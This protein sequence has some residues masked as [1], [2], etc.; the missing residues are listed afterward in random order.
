MNRFYLKVSERAQ[1]V[2]EYCRAPELASNFP[3]EVEHIRPLAFDGKAELGN[4]A[5]ACRSCN[6]YKSNYLK[7]IDEDG[8]ETERLFNPRID[9]WQEHFFIDLED[10]IIIGLSEIGKGTINR[11]R[12]NNSLQ[13]QARKQWHRLGI[14]P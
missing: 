11:L 9:I 5:L 6:I 4:L 10:F 8:A 2:C 14:F 7:G 3:F 13:R 1:K 12:F